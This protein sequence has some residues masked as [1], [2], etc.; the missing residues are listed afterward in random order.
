MSDDTIAK[1]LYNEDGVAMAVTS[2]VVLPTSTSAYVVAGVDA[3][4]VVRYLHLGPDGNLFVT[5]T[6]SMLVPAT[7]HAFNELTV[8]ANQP[9]APMSVA[10]VERLSWGLQEPD[11]GNADLL[12]EVRVV[13]N[14]PEFSCK[15]VVALDPIITV[16]V[17]NA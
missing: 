7:Q 8:T 13:S 14:E 2:G 4:N 3:S 15:P 9:D 1:V 17:T 11:E 5:G 12:V 10:V 16:R 6:L